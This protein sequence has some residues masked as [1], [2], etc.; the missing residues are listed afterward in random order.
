MRRFVLFVQV[1]GEEGK[2]FG[3]NVGFPVLSQLDLSPIFVR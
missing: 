2:K 3:D 1:K